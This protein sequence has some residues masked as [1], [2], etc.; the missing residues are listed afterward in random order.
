MDNYT[1]VN[2]VF[3]TWISSILKVTSVQLNRAV[4]EIEKRKM[5]GFVTI[6]IKVE[7]FAPEA[8][9]CYL[10]SRCDAYGAP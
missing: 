3:G 1:M 7:V 8:P 2:Q 9:F 6:D 5:I 4:R 10:W